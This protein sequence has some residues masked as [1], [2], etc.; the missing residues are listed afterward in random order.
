VN[1]SNN[2]KRNKSQK[3]LH[4]NQKDGASLSRYQ[5]QYAR[6]ISIGDDCFAADDVVA[7]ERNYQCA[8]HYL[9]MIG[10]ISSQLPAKTADTPQQ[11]QVDSPTYPEILPIESREEANGTTAAGDTVSEAVNVDHYEEAKMASTTAPVDEANALSPEKAP[12][13]NKR[14]PKAVKK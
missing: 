12:T 11:D 8:E 1:K 14:K 5:F 4:Q 9:R 6:Y 10:A 13:R 7:A 3:Q 2:R